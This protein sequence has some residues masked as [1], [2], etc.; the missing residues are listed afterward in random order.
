MGLFTLTTDFGTQD[1]Y[2]GAI[3]GYLLKQLP[4]ALIVDISHQIEPQHLSQAAYCI[5]RAC[6]EFPAHCIH[7][8][9]VDPDVGSDR[10]ALAVR[11]AQHWYLSPD[12][13]VLSF[14]IADHPEAQIYQLHP[15]TPWWQKHQS[16][17]AL[18]LFAPAA[19]QLAA[20]RA[21]EEMG[22]LLESPVLLKIPKVHIQN[23][24]LLCQIVGFDRFGNAF[25]NLS[26]QHYKSIQQP[27]TQF[28]LGVHTLPLNRHY[29]Q[30]RSGQPFVI[31]NSDQQLEIAI[32]QGSAQ[33]LLNLNMHDTLKII[34]AGPAEPPLAHP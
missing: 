9:V 31:F 28:H 7:L 34:P 24:Q 21:I 16:F 12:N 29:A 10:L 14:I 27:H 4:H 30:G 22:E 26:Q 5:R 11:T 33:K 8:V 13:G 20:G 19:A 1:G 23:D 2:V 15:H 17:D 18:A 6:P 32:Y 3:K 25:T